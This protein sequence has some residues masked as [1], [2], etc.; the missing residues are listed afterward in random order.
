MKKCI[1]LGLGTILL[2]VSFCL[3]QDVDLTKKEQTKKG[4]AETLNPE[5]TAKNRGILQLC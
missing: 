1:L 5:L 2:V 3:G 4:L